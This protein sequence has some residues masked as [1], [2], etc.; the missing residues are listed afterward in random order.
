MKQ[1]KLS[2]KL[3][4]ARISLGLTLRQVERDAAMFGLRISNC[5]LCQIEKGYIQDVN[6]NLLRMLAKILKLDYMELLIL[7]GYVTVRDLKLS[8]GRV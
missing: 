2:N 5:Y 6:P 3:H 7:A 8:K 4:Q 1:K